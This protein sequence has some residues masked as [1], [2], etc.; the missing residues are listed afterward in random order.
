MNDETGRLG[1]SVAT[2]ARMAATVKDAVAEHAGP[3]A[4]KVRETAPKLAREQGKRAKDVAGEH[5]KGALAAAI[6]AFGVFVTALLRRMRRTPSRKK[7][8]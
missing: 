6:T 8:S 4:A 5:P 1:Q 2:G 7:Q 3:L